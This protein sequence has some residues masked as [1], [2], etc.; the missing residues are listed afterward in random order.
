M[1]KRPDTLPDDEF[2]AE[3]GESERAVRR[4][5]YAAWVRSAAEFRGLL[6]VMA[7]WFDERNHPDGAVCRADWTPRAVNSRTADPAGWWKWSARPPEPTGWDVRRAVFR[8]PSHNSRLWLCWPR[9]W[10][11][12]TGGYVLRAGYEPA[13]VGPGGEWF[14][15]VEDRVTTPDAWCVCVQPHAT[16]YG[17]PACNRHGRAEWTKLF[18]PHDAVWETPAAVPAAV[19]APQPT[20][21]DAEV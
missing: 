9:G 4:A 16:K 20:L 10:V 13:H 17:T 1:P 2:P 15:G 11:R 12:F 8:T 19:P 5:L 7:D 18:H 3:M 6:P 21:F 14:V